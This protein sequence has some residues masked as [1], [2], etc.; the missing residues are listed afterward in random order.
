[1]S[2]K[3]L[4]YWKRYRMTHREEY[5]AIHR[6]SRIKLKADVIDA[7]G[8][9]C[10]CCGEWRIEFL[11]IDHVDGG[12]TQH[13]IALATKADG[14]VGGRRFYQLL[15]IQG[16]PAGYEVMCWNCNCGRQLNGGTCPHKDRSRKH[17]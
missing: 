17:A 15:R 4:P 2:G 12:G 14:K 3:I 7:Y 10:S 6:R 1:M 8:G 16:Y 13:R 9:K 5:R 11:T